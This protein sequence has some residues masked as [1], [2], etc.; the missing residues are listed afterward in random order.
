MESP[1]YHYA[2]L[3]LVDSL[4]SSFKEHALTKK[5]VTEFH[6]AGEAA[7]RS[8]KLKSLTFLLK[9]HKD[10]YPQGILD[11]IEAKWSVHRR[12]RTDFMLEMDVRTPWKSVRPFPVRVVVCEGRTWEYE[13]FVRTSSK[14]HVAWVTSRIKARHQN[15]I[16]LRPLSLEDI[17]GAANLEVYP[18]HSRCLVEKTRFAG[19]LTAKDVPF[20]GHQH[21]HWSPDADTRTVAQMAKSCPYPVLVLTDHSTSH[22]LKKNTQKF[23]DECFEASWIKPVL[24]GIEVDLDLEGNTEGWTPEQL[25]PFKYRVAAIHHGTRESLVSRY[26][27]AIESGLFHCIAHPYTELAPRID[28]EDTRWDLVFQACKKH[29]VS[30]EINGALDRLDLHSK[31]AKCAKS[32][33]C[34]FV[35]ASGAHSDASQNREMGYALGIAQKALLVSNDLRKL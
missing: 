30:L 1:N 18:E 7:R 17:Y 14:S 9:A 16:D 11:S 25:A 34:T 27:K 32:Y 26:L 5:G 35:L 29:N 4:A 28:E 31:M 8:E 33:G 20:D 24:P 21:S 12:D 22:T 19:L 6:L 10:A 13:K 2:R 23:V 15:K 3:P